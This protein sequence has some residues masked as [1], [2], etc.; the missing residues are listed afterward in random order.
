MKFNYTYLNTNSIN[1]LILIFCLKPK[2]A[3]NTKINCNQ[4]YI[5]KGSTKEKIRLHE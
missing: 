1:T 2:R 4:G 3:Q 5:I